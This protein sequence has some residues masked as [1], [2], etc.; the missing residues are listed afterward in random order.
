MLF[1]RLIILLLI[2]LLASQSILAAMDVHLD[3]LDHESELMSASSDHVHKLVQSESYEQLPTAEG[4]QSTSGEPQCGHCAYCHSHLS[5]MV[6]RSPT[7]TSLYDSSAIASTDKYAP[8]KRIENILRPPI[9][10]A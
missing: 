4:D 9:I 3:G 2:N 1:Q 6:S 8:Q 7:L 10:S 5:L